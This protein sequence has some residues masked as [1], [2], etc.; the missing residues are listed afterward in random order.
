MN[1][2]LQSPWPFSWIGRWH[3]ALVFE[4]RAQVLARML[5]EQIPHG[6]TVLDIGCGDGTIASLIAQSRPD[7]AIQGVEVMVRPGCKVE[8]RTFDGKTL[9]FADDSFNVCVL[10]DV[11]HHTE[12]VG[13]LLAEATRVGR[14]ILIKDHLDETLFDD[15][16]LRLMDWVGNRPHGVRL[17]Y[18]YQSRTQ[19]KEHFL[20]CGLEEVSWTTKVPIYAA[21][22]RF[23]AGRGL[24]FVSLQK[25]TQGA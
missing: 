18:N 17:T 13:V 11:L 7:I 9:P 4:R 12:D 23:V 19:W 5:A 8:C 14:L 20:K 15:A 25:R 16:T 6:S 21:P 24:H 10:V 2:P 22:F 1:E 3:R